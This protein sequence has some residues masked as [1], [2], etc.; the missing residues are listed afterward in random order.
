MASLND[1]SL[2]DLFKLTS[3]DRE[4][5]L[6][7]GATAR[8]SQ[9]AAPGE[10]P[11]SHLVDRF[12]QEATRKLSSLTHERA[13]GAP[14]PPTGSSFLTGGADPLSVVDRLVKNIFAPVQD[15]EIFEASP[16]KFTQRPKTLEAAPVVGRKRDPF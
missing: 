13:F 11:S 5:F 2:D 10:L 3:R 7:R 16:G 8:A 12:L 14:P 9:F 6:R 1:V 4:D 15:M